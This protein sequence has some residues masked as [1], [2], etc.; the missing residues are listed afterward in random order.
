MSTIVMI[1]K[2]PSMPGQLQVLYRIGQNGR[3][4]HIA[5]TSDPGEAAAIALANVGRGQYV[6][7]GPEKVMQHIPVEL[8]SSP[9]R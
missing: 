4:R 3:L 2:Y 8:R 6:I 7:I 9:G 5:D 1:K